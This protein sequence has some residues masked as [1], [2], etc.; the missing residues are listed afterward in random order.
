M[1]A[2]ELGDDVG[3]RKLPHLQQ[4]E[5]VIDEIGGF[6]GHT[7]AILRRRGE[8]E[9][10]AFLADLLRDLQHAREASRAV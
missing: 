9:L 4:Q 5:Q 3:E 6:G 8:R 7:R 10:D 2:L 1:A